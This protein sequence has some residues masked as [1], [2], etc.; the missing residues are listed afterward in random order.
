MVKS[1]ALRQGFRWL[2]APGEEV[3]SAAKNAELGSGC[4]SLVQ[5]LLSADG[6][7]EG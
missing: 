7:G 5:R 6:V 4:L 1:W 3:A 2:V